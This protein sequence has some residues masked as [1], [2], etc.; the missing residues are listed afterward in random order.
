[1]TQWKYVEKSFSGQWIAHVV[2]ERN[3]TESLLHITHR[4]QFQVK[5]SPKWDIL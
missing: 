3:Q 4:N 2:T 1:M 5:K